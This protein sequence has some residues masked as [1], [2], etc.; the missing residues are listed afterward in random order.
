MEEFESRRNR[1]KTAKGGGQ[2]GLKA[3]NKT[4]KANRC[5]NQPRDSNP[6]DEKMCNA[7]ED[8]LLTSDK[9]RKW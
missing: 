2:G 4:G 3:G 5:G 1:S 9:F 8:H 7:A 6:G